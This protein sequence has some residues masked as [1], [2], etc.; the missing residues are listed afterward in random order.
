MKRA[1]QS[2]CVACVLI[3]A[4]LWIADEVADWRRVGREHAAVMA[5]LDS[6]RRAPLVPAKVAP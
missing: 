5:T 6:M 1:A 3:L 2:V 4:A